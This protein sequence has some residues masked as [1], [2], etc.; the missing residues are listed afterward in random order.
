MNRLLAVAVKELRQI[1]RDPFSLVMLIALPA[2]ML[3]LYGFALNFDVRHVRLA[4]QDRDQQRASRDLVAAFT[5]LDL[6]RPGRDARR[7]R[8]PGALCWSGAWP[9]RCS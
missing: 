2:F 4:V 5:Q 1:R 8:G 6:L 9:R 3:V 7:R